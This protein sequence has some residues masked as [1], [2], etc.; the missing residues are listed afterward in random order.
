MLSSISFL[1]C[2]VKAKGESFKNTKAY[3]EWESQTPEDRKVFYPFVD[4]D[5]NWIKKPSPALIKK[6]ILNSTLPYLKKKGKKWIVN[7]DYKKPKQRS[8]SCSEKS[9]LPIRQEKERSKSAPLPKN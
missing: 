9:P 1:P 7:L 5:G 3:A 4:V 8:Q 6:N 2:S